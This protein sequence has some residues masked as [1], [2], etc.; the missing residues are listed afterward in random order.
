MKK[1]LNWIKWF[2]SFSIRASLKY[3]KRA[4]LSKEQFLLL[5]EAY[6]IQRNQHMND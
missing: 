6:L 1:I 2:L 3:I 5:R 4:D